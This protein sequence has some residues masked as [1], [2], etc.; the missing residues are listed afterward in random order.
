MLIIG[1]AQHAVK[2]WQHKQG[3]QHG[4]EDDGGGEEGRTSA[5]VPVAMVMGTTQARRRARS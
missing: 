5:L 4:A 3:E 2:R 1:Q